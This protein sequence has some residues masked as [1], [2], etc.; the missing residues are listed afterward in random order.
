MGIGI[1]GYKPRMLRLIGRIGD[2][3]LP[4]SPYLPPEQLAE[5]NLRIDEGAADAGRKPQDVRRL[6]NIAGTFTGGG[7]EFLQ[8]PPKVWVEQLAELAL[9]E[10]MSAFILMARAGGETDL[11]RGGAEGA[12]AARGPG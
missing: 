1:G 12:P 6:Y 3:W 8:G 4:S 10:G 11:A 9:S 5:A 2:G 7:R